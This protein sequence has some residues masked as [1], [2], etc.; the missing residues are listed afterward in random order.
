[1]KTRYLVIILIL[2]TTVFTYFTVQKM[3]A[4]A[5]RDYKVLLWDKYEICFLVGPE[6]TITK[7]ENSFKYTAGKNTGEFTIHSREID[8]TKKKTSFGDFEGA[9]S[10]EVDF[11]NFE[12]KIVPGIILLDKFDFAEKKYANLLPVRANCSK[13]LDR[14]PVLDNL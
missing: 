2:C 8:E 11:R 14:F 9:Y 10:K 4:N 12:Y 5:K 7:T 3:K 6:Y 13:Y 1:M